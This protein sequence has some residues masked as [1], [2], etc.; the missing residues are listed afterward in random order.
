MVDLPTEDKQIDEVEHIDGAKKASDGDNHE[1]CHYVC[2]KDKCKGTFT[3]PLP[4]WEQ[5]IIQ[6]AQATSEGC[7][8]NR[9]IQEHEDKYKE[10]YTVETRA[11]NGACDLCCPP[12]KT[13]KGPSI[14]V[15]THITMF[16]YIYEYI[17][18]YCS[19]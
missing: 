12:E 17:Y 16:I 7:C 3:N 8:A 9:N 11:G 2:W 1:S 19:S 15:C 5:W 6:D 10:G 14:P 18:T 4:R 13:Q